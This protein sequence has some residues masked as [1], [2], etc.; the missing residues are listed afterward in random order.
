M[1]LQ[2]NIRRVLKEETQ[3]I[4]NEQLIEIFYSRL[5]KQGKLNFNGIIL[6][7]ELEDDGQKRIIFNID[8]PNDLSYSQAV[9]EN[10]IDK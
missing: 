6:I 9:I 3:R 5:T 4:S 8:N 7:P 2:E 10:Y 1:D